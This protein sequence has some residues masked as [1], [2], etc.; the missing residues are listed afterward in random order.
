MPW[1]QIGRPDVPTDEEMAILDTG[2]TTW[3]HIIL[4]HTNLARRSAPLERSPAGIQVKKCVSAKQWFEAA[5]NLLWH[6]MYAQ[7]LQPR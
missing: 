4:Q 7:E 6:K 2:D 3:N 1:L 5:S